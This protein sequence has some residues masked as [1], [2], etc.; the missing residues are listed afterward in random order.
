[1]IFLCVQV[2]QS[3][4]SVQT[5]V[6]MPFANL[7][8]NP[9]L[10]WIN[11][12]FPELLQDRL[13]WPNVNPLGRDERLIA[14]DRIGIPYSSRLSKASLIKIGQELDSNYLILG[15]FTYDGKRL[16]AST[17]ILDL[18]RNLLG[19]E[20]KEGGGLEELQFIIG[21]VA[22]CIIKQLDTHVSISE[23]AYYARFPTIPN[24]ALEN[25]IRG[26]TESD[27]SKQIRYF[28]E[29]EKAY[30]NYPEAIFQLGKVYSLQKDYATSSLWLQR[31]TL[32]NKN[33][34]AATFLLGLD[35]L[36]LKSY[37][38]AAGEFQQLSQSLPLNEIYSNLGIAMSF[39]GQNE[40]ATEAFEK[41][42]E[43]DSSSADSHFNL[44]YHLW[45][46]G[47]FG[48][49]EQTL[50]ALVQRN[51]QDGQAY[52]LLYKCQR[53]L[54]KTTEAEASWA[55]ARQLTP[56]VDS[57]ESRKRIPDLFRIQSNFDETTFR[58]LRLEIEQL[59]N[60]KTTGQAGEQK[61]RGTLGRPQ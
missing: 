35:Y 22:W 52:Y 49:A 43:G 16:Q 29:A 24:A 42:L 31:L 59:H 9:A 61:I 27:I 11:E 5:V 6:V 34:S 40:K 2:S 36:Q 7:S 45:R 3:L 38:K 39:C 10:Q 54:G 33:Y 30:P 37:E 15:D 53:A 23:E 46:T 44:A 51:D 50:R 8:K 48:K 4:A 28:R 18:R 32:K 12:S 25:Y 57:W 26:L 60:N 58:L 20:V 41:A 55:V 13:I 19:P 47:E 17:S 1:M 56:Q 21:K 14:F